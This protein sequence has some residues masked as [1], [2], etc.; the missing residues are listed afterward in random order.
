MCFFK[1]NYVPVEVHYC[2]YADMMFLIKG[3]KHSCDLQ[4]DARSICV[5]SEDGTGW[6]VPVF[7][8]TPEEQKECRMAYFNAVKAHND[9]LK[10]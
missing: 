1:K 10:K 5:M 8:Y 4:N 2:G 6:S 7:M 9:N 3:Q